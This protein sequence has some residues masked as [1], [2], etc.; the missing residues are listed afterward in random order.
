MASMYSQI[1]KEQAAEQKICPKC[2]RLM[3]SFSGK[4]YCQKCGKVEK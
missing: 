4:W 1:K 3:K 2:L